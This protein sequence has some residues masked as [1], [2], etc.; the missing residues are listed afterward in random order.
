MSFYKLI[1]NYYSEKVSGTFIPNSVCWIY[2]KNIQSVF[3]SFMF[4]NNKMVN[5]KY[6]GIEGLVDPIQVYVCWCPAITDIFF[7]IFRFI[8]GM[9]NVHTLFCNSNVLRVGN[10]WLISICEMRLGMFT[11]IPQLWIVTWGVMVGSPTN[12]IRG[13]K[14]LLGSQYWLIKTSWSVIRYKH[15]GSTSNCYF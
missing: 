4:A 2:T 5:G 11:F 8:I 6:P 7:G 9:V 15:L 13:S 12:Y 3:N 14:V 1:T 10:T